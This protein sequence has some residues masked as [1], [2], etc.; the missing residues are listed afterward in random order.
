MAVTSLLPV[1]LLLRAGEPAGFPGGPCCVI[2]ETRCALCA[3]A[4]LLSSLLLL[5][6]LLLAL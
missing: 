4:L 2:L 6:L 3:D 5:L 1:P